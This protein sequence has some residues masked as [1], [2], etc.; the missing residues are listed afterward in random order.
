[1]IKHMN[2]FFTK[3]GTTPRYSSEEEKADEMMA[4]AEHDMQYVWGEEQKLFD[5]WKE[6]DRLREAGEHLRNKIDQ[7]PRVRTQ[8]D[9]NEV[10]AEMMQ[11]AKLDFPELFP[12]ETK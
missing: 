8:A 11:Q 9:R 2:N 5:R 1:M 7:I 3:V 12:K 10:D 4:Q 6:Q